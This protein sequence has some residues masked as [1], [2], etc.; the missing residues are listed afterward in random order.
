M[1]M[2]EKNQLEMDDP[3]DGT[4]KPIRLSYFVKGKKYI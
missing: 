4:H 1:Q 3:M 2:F